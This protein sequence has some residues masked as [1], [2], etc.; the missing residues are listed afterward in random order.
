MLLLQKHTADGH[1]IKVYMKLRHCKI[2]F[3]VLGESQS[4]SFSQAAYGMGEVGMVGETVIL[5]VRWRCTRGVRQ[6]LLT[7]TL[8]RAHSSKLLSLLSSS[9]LLEKLRCCCTAFTEAISDH[10]TQKNVKDL[11]KKRGLVW[12][13]TC[14]LN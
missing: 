5:L 6:G 10:C 1:H 4:R 11:R 13:L 7:G 12:Q 8:L 14:K 2:T 3:G 9:P